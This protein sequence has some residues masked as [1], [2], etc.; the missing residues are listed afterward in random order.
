MTTVRGEV[1]QGK[2]AIEKGLPAIFA[3]RATNANLRTFNYE[4]RFTPDVALVYV[5]NEPSGPVGPDGQTLPAHQKLSLR[6]FAGQASSWV[7][8]A[9]HNTLVEA[10]GCEALSF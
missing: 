1:M 10:I 3:S 8:K 5:S 9:L 4:I 7:V 6:V 2:M